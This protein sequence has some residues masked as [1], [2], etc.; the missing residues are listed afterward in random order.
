MLDTSPKSKTEFLASLERLTK[1]AAAVSHDDMA[2][3]LKSVPEQ[4]FTASEWGKVVDFALDQLGQWQAKWLFSSARAPDTRAEAQN[5]A[6]EHLW[7]VFSK[8]LADKVP[9]IEEAL[10]RKKDLST[11]KY[12]LER[13]VQQDRGA[14]KLASLVMSRL[15]ITLNSL[16]FRGIAYSLYKRALYPSG[17]VGRAQS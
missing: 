3:A 4:D 1:E 13:K 14:A 6:W 15:A 5:E 16:G 8:A 17:S 11:A 10:L 7:S 2:R 9:G 12:L